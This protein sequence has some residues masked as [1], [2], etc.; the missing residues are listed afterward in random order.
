MQK[1]AMPSSNR[2]RLP[3]ETKD[4]QLAANLNRVLN[5]QQHAVSKFSKSGTVASVDV[6]SPVEPPPLLLHK[7]K[8][9]APVVDPGT[10]KEEPGSQEELGAR[11]ETLDK[12]NGANGPGNEG[13]SDTTTSAMVWEL[14]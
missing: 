4:R 11:T 10:I 13:G 7:S 12:Q 3:R 9:A 14:L 5:L 8:T 1:K 2:Q 6:S